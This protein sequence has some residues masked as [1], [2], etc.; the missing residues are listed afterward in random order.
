MRKLLVGIFSLL[1]LPFLV[2]PVSGANERPLYDQPG[3]LVIGLCSDSL[4]GATREYELRKNQGF[5]FLHLRD[6][7][8]WANRFSSKTYAVIYNVFDDYASAAAYAAQERERGISAYVEHSGR[9]TH[10]PLGANGY[11]VIGICTTNQDEVWADFRAHKAPQLVNMFVCFSSNYEGFAPGYYLVSYGVFK[12]VGEANDYADYI[13]GQGINVY[14][15]YG[16][17]KG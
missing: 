3:Y 10:G 2:I 11:F 4:L 5:S 16:E 9:R 1:L 12:T 17:W 6:K 13:R 14:V 8:Y 7:R 15:K